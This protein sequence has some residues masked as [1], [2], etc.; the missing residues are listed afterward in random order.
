M[1][2]KFKNKL[3]HRIASIL[4]EHINARDSDER[5]VWH[6]IA[7]YYGDPADLSAEELLMAM[8]NRTMP[9]FESISRAR[10]K[11]QE[12]REDLRG[13][14]YAGRKRRATQMK[15]LFKK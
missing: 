5:V 13:E 3:M 10:R 12:E 6:Y 8:H 11:V 1:K 7:R 15:T 2:K 9:R 14:T 4:E